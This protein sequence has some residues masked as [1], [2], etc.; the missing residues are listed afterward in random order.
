MS[1]YEMLDNVVQ[2][3]RKNGMFCCDLI[4]PNECGGEFVR[5]L[6]HKMTT[7]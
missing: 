2:N 1:A 5:T 6:Y 7:Q 4:K 3:P